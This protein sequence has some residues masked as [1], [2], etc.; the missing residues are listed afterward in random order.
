MWTMAETNASRSVAAAIRSA[1][2]SL[3]R[4]AK[5]LNASCSSS[6]MLVKW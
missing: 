5:R 2:R 4:W 6:S 1:N 3:M